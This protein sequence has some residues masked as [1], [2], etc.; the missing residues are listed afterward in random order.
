VTVSDG[1]DEFEFSDPMED[2]A[3]AAVAQKAIEQFTQGGD[4]S[5]EPPDLADPLDGPVHL[6]VG[7]R[8]VA[9]DEGSPT[10]VEVR[11]AWVREL[12]G[13][14]E[15]KIAKA[16][17]KDDVSAFIFAV[18]ESG[19]ERLGDQTPTREDIRSLTSADR[20]YLLLEIA[21][22]TYGDDMT[23][24]NVTC[25]CG[26]QLT[27]TISL[28]EDVPVKRFDSLDEAD[29]DIRLKSGKVA[30]ASLP[31]VSLDD[32]I[33]KAGTP[34]EVN[35]VLVAHCVEEVRGPKGD[36]RIAGDQAAARRLGLRDRQDII[37][38][39]SEHTPGPQYNDVRFKHEPDGCGEEI[40]LQVSVGDMFRG[41]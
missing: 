28:A 13:E 36:V 34:A 18:L 8:R 12:T 40:R 32:E 21:R 1:A 41:L 26:E 2:P 30:R 37:L 14:H 11:E 15:E 29:F 25:S 31:L 3:T 6:P 27:V 38:G 19:I 17:L 7:F 24:E 33:S 23:Y 20:D 39:I 16:R 35:T 10:F 9:L 4:A 22:A 5:E